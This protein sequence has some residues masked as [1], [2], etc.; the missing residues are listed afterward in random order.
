MFCVPYSFLEIS[1]SLLVTPVPCSVI[2][3]PD[4]GFTVLRP[5]VIFQPCLIL[6]VIFNLCLLDIRIISVM[7]SPASN[8]LWVLDLLSF[9]SL[10]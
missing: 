2:T 1:S 5:D 7:I 4:F 3:G 9:F 8:F 10:W 6:P